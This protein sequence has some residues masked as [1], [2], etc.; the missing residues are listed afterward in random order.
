M[1]TDSS[2]IQTRVLIVGAGPAGLGISLALKRAGVVDQLVV[3]ARKVGAAFRA[4]PKTM[5]LLTPS[6]FSNAFGLTDLNSID[7]DSS[8]ADYLHTQHPK[9]EGYAN[10]L[11]A[12]V[13]HFQLPVRTGLEVTAVKKTTA[14][15]V[16]ESSQ[17][18]IYADYVIW[19]AGQFF[20]PRDQDFPGS[21]HALHS[22][23]FVTGPNS[24]A[25]STQS[26]EV[27]RA[28]STPLSTSSTTRNRCVSFRVENPGPLT[29][30]TL[31]A[32]LARERWIG[33]VNCS[34]R[35]RKLSASNS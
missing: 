24:K 6:F 13:A 18:T 1:K 32:H 35:Q 26:L 8:P 10:Y 11:E 15:F 2:I 22:S 27:T 25:S 19:A 29:T 28:G 5:S 34:L 21:H 31:L 20:Y 17:G 7:P 33:Y 12:V 9:G 23:K 4:W 3:D 14:G 16:V 30:P